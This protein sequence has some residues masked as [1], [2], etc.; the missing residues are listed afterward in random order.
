[1]FVPF[2]CRMPQTLVRKFWGNLARAFDYHTKPARFKEGR[3]IFVRVCTFSWSLGR[4]SW[5]SSCSCL[6]IRFGSTQ[7]R[8]NPQVC[9]TVRTCLAALPVCQGSDCPKPLPGPP[10]LEILDQRRQC[11]PRQQPHAQLQ[12]AHGRSC[13]RTNNGNNMSIAVCCCL[14]RTKCPFFPR[15]IEDPT[16]QRTFSDLPRA[17]IQLGQ[18]E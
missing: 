12:H 2:S 7:L 11:C 10:V 1:M 9:L 14:T 4:I 17:C 5:N 18:K 15:A 6:Y 13:L 8:Q 3:F 16:I